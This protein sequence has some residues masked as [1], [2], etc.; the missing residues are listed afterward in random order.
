MN[1][2]NPVNKIGA[3]LLI[4]VALITLTYLLLPNGRSVGA[5]PQLQPPGTTNKALAASVRADQ[6]RMRMALGQLPLSFEMNR[7]QF[8]PQVRF[9]SRGA[10]YKAFFTQSEM[11]FVLR[12]PAATQL[13]NANPTTASK[14]TK[15]EQL[16]QAQKEREERAASKAV[17]RMSLAGANPEAQ[18]TGVSELPGKINYFR[19]NE[20]QKW[21]T[22]VPTFRR[23]SYTGVYSGI[24]LIYY[25]KGGQLEY[26]LVV[27]PG[28]DPSRIAFTFDGAERV[29]VDAATG[30]LVVTAAGGAQLRQ[31]KPLIYQDVDGSKRAVS[32]GFTADGNGARFSIGDY[33]RSR[34]LVI[35]P[36]IINYSTYL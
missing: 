12:N 19:G 11:V 8:D 15:A 5:A 28:A 33:D 1:T 22:D 21:I 36:A 3:S 25:G 16:A 7:G 34:P 4:T 32:G 13:A 31:G 14:A 9:A 10:S 27:A 17:V 30:A 24:D 29:E 6:K 20:E 35:H 18:V 26:D 23:V 2:K